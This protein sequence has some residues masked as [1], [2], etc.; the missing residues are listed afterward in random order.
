MS[1][2]GTRVV[3]IE[4]PRLLTTGATYVDDLRIPQLAGAAFVTYVRSPLAHARITGIDV[5]A[6]AEAPGVVAVFTANDLDDVPPPPA[7]N[8][9]A[10]PLLAK[11]VVRYVGEPV[12]M[13]ITETRAQGEDAAELVAVDYEPLPAVVD[14]EEA[15]KD[16]VLLFPEAGTNIVAPN[17]PEEFDDAPFEACEVVIER[18]FRNQ[19]VAPVPMEV[20][21]AAAAWDGERVTVWSSNQNAQTT[22]AIIAGGLGVEPDKVRVIT[23]DVG[24][25]FGAKIGVDRDTVLVA[26]AA[27][28]LNRA[29]RWTETRSESLIAMQ[30]GRAQVHK[31]KLG[32]NRDGKILAYRIDFMQDGGAYPRVGP[33]LANFTTL[34]APAVYEIPTVQIRSKVVL[35]NTTPVGAYRGAGRPEAT[36]TIERLVDIF[37]A[38]IGMDPAEVRRRNLIP[39]DK[40]PYT[41]PTGLVYDS[42]EYVKALDRVLEAAGYAELR[43]EQERRRAAGDTKVLGIGLSSYVEVTALDFPNGET[44]RVVIGRDGSATVYTG[45]HTQGQGHATSWAMIVQDQ[46]G[47][48]MDK[49]TV[50][51]GDTDAIPVGTGTY[52]SRSL[53]VGGIAVHECAVKIKEKARE[54]AARELEADPNDLV[55]DTATGSWHVQG[56][57]GTKLDWARLA[58]LA[59][60]EGLTADVHFKP[61]R[62]TFP[63][64]AHLAVVEVD[65]ETG[66]V[67][68]LRHISL[69]DAGPLINPII[70]EGQR[71]GGIAQGVAQALY[72]EMAYD[73]E[74]NPITANLAD[75]PMISAAELPSFELLTMETPTDVNPL[76]VKGI[77]EAGTIGA[78]PAV[79]NAVVDALSH[80]GVRHI[81][82]PATP[83]RVWKAINEARGSEKRAAQ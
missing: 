27:R 7:D 39:A 55:L 25:G 80:L 45:S 51:H 47:I 17:G 28:R 57:P 56:V 37:A 16:E 40:F 65:T 26:W 35:T 2:L 54:L 22:R 79:Q 83:E 32:G 48:P 43:A 64:G 74:G 24:G 31:V 70:A 36:A 46:L 60:E 4:D 13:V 11:D 1:V 23:P 44:G 63:F 61:S 9:L 3:R 14:V 6:A 42:G 34:M 82:M 62:P 67:R 33:L 81:E 15:V 77:G 76:G 58:E 49:V 69:D 41:T 73:A 38:E 12:A 59:G 18:T 68:L 30:H 72:E 21:S 29:V 5:S 75:Y 53:Q 19:R 52:A 10:E 50:I 8:P 71:H 20:R 78:T 66:Q